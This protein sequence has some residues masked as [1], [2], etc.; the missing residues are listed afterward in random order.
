M[1]VFN[2]LLAKHI[3]PD[4]WTPNTHMDIRPE[5]IRSRREQWGIDRLG[6]LPRGHHGMAGPGT[7][8]DGPIVI[9]Q[10]QGA[11]RLLDGSHR[12]NTW[13]AMRDPAQHS[14]HIHTI[15]GAGEFV[16]LAPT[17]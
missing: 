13:I 16:E 1:D 14:V 12:V 10:Y 11:M 3:R 8:L 17:G 2:R 9:V 7:R 6:L 4:G 5:Q 15:E